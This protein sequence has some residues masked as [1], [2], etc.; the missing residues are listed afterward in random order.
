M[1]VPASQSNDQTL[2]NV[3]LPQLQDLCSTH[4]VEA[5]LK[6]LNMVNSVIAESVVQRVLTQVHLD[7]IKEIVSMHMQGLLLLFL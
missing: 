5:V 6:Q 7:G 1:E 3:V 4:I 2:V